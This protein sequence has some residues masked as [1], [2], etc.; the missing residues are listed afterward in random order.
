MNRVG[1]K[2]STL[3]SAQLPLFSYPVI[4]SNIIL[5]STSNILY[6]SI[7]KNAPYCCHLANPKHSVYQCYT[8]S[9]SSLFLTNILYKSNYKHPLSNVNLY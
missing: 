2:P 7:A 3:L 9:P 1:V 5:P 6:K 4:P 8:I